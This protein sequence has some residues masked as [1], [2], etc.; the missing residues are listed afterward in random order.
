MNGEAKKPS[1]VDAVFDD[2]R[3]ILD[4]LPSDE[5]AIARAKRA[6]L[7][8]GLDRS[9]RD[10]KSS[11]P[12]A[13]IAVSTTVVAAVVALLFVGRSEPAL[14]F[15]VDDAP[16]RTGAWLAAES[17]PR[18]L[19]FDDA[20]ELVLAPESDAT[21]AS[22]TSRGARVVL[23]RG[24]LRAQITHR[25][26]TEWNLDAGPFQIRVVGTAFETEWSPDA[27]YFELTVSEG[28]V[29]VEGPTLDARIV[30]AGSAVRVWVREERARTDEAPSVPR[31]SEA[32]SES[33]VETSD[34]E[35]ASTEAE[36]AEAA[37]PT[38][39]RRA[40]DVRSEP[41][42]AVTL[43]RS[44]RFAEAIAAVEAAGVER[45]LRAS[46]PMERLELADAARYARDASLAKRFYEAGPRTGDAGARAAFGLAR[47]ALDLPADAA[48]SSAAADRAEAIRWLRTSL[49]RSS[50]GALAREARG[51]L[52]ELLHA[53]GDPSAREV[54]NEYLA[55]H[56]DGPQAE[57][58]RRIVSP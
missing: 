51:R 52:M 20:S 31:E 13:W 27:A 39:A 45:V 9:A 50:R 42:D 19:R 43:A 15:A 34:P 53:S 18:T 48:G 28:A 47:V 36:L 16:G 2:A 38:R 1:R 35:H 11:R 55:Q 24:R 44:G 29:E 4:G 54:A 30:R 10:R 56:P 40:E 17:V 32:E 6:V 26:D 21:I 46:T 33:G 41:N 8:D 25:D 14:T 22:T 49:R 7:D 57:A 5:A 23:T 12:W 58:A 37:Q 3:T